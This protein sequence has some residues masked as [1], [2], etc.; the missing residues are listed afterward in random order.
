MA[1]VPSGGIYST[2]GDPN[3]QLRVKTKCRVWR[4]TPAIP[5]LG[6]PPLDDQPPLHNKSEASL[7]YRSLVS[8]SE[9]IGPARQLSGKNA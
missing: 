4:C 1:P 7:G 3:K 9:S 5:A 2:L 6:R 8:A